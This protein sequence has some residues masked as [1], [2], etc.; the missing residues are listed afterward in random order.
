MISTVRNDFKST[1]LEA[2]EEAVRRMGRKNDL[3]RECVSGK[4]SGSL[5]VYGDDLDDTCRYILMR[6]PIVITREMSQVMGRL[7]K[8]KKNGD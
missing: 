1:L 6:N 7:K 4:L 2:S 3:M 5:E 8:G